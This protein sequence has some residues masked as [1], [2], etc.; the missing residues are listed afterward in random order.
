MVPRVTASGSESGVSQRLE[1]FGAVAPQTDQ[2]GGAGGGKARAPSP[3][4]GRPRRGR[5]R[6][7]RQ[8]PRLP[9]QGQPPSHSKIY[10]RRRHWQRKK[11]LH[12]GDPSPPATGTRAGGVRPA[13]GG[14]WRR[15]AQ[16]D[17]PGAPS[18][19]PPPSARDLRRRLGRPGSGSGPAPPPTC[20]ARAPC[21]F[22]PPPAGGQALLSER[23]LDA[24]GTAAMFAP[25]LLDF[26]KTKYAR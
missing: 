3:L 4:G 17:W 10:G 11:G 6:A 20:C 15:G 14:R 7:R 12:L 5:G 19:A 22:P 25:R 2:A 16:G 21:A 26:Q 9:P 18:P 24:D 1:S 13:Q 23:R 8:C